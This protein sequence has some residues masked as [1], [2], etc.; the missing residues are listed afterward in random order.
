MSRAVLSW[1]VERLDA[2]ERVALA[3]VIEAK[4]SVPGKPGA[5]LAVSS[6]GEKFGTVGG[7]GLELRIEKGLLDLLS[8]S[9]S[10]M[11]KTGGKIENFILYK[12]GKGQEQVALDSLCGGQLRVS[13]EVIEPV[14]HV[15]IAGGGHVGMSVSIVCDTLGWQHS[16]FDIREEYSNPEKYSSATEVMTSSVSDFL[17]GETTSSIGRFSDILIMGHDWSVD[18]ELLIGLLNICKGGTRIGV[19]GS[20]TKWDGFT[21]AA[22]ESGLTDD[23]ISIARCPIG[24]EIGADSPE[25]IALAICAEILALERGSI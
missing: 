5:K 20:K 12:E 14:P 22:L 11:R 1:V 10:D 2:G 8:K 4:G 17:Q 24:L 6:T 21:R 16:V 25:E 9:K 18:Q 23:E 15:L 19:I 3:S 7:A 13:M